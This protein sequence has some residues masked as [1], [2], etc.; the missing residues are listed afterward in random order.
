[1]S[2]VVNPTDLRSLR[3]N[4]VVMGSLKFHFPGVGLLKNVL[5]PY[6]RSSVVT[7]G[8]GRTQKASVEEKRAVLRSHSSSPFLEASQIIRT[9]IATG[10]QCQTHKALEGRLVGHLG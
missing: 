8:Q 1:L 3:I 7:C 10:F 5:K 6:P 9:P 4:L 2:E